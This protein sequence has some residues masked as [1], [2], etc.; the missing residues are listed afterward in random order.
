[1]ALSEKA[2]QNKTNYNLKYSKEHYKRIPLDVT[3]ETYNDIK[4]AATSCGETV[5]GYI[6]KAV[7]TRLDTE[8]ES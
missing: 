5:N 7:Q 6:K 4:T 2:Q 8:K 3:N 1:M